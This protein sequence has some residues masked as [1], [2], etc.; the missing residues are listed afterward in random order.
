VVVLLI[1][2]VEV[3][4]QL[5]VDKVILLVDLIQQWLVEFLLK[6]QDKEKSPMPLEDSLKLEMLNIPHS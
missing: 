1:V 3:V 5:V 4:Q 6:L 2:L